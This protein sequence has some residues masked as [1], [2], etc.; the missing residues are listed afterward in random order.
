[1]R[2]FAIKLAY[3]TELIDCFRAS[4]FTK[5]LDPP[6]VQTDRNRHF[7]QNT[8]LSRKLE[9]LYTESFEKSF[10]LYLQVV[11]TNFCYIRSKMSNGFQ[12]SY[13]Y[14][15][16]KT[17]HISL[18]KIIMQFGVRSRQSCLNFFF[19]GGDTMYS[20]S[21]TRFGDWPYSVSSNRF[22]LQ[23]PNRF[24]LTCTNVANDLILTQLSWHSDITVYDKCASRNVY[25]IHHLRNRG[26]FERE[27][28]GTPLPTLKCFK[29][30]LWTQLRTIFW[31]ICTRLH[32]FAY[33]NP[34][35]FQ[36]IS[37]DTRRNVPGA[38]IHT[39]ISAWLASV[40]IVTV[41]RNNHWC[42]I[43]FYTQNDR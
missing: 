15:I 34:T 41:L 7:F 10:A 8:V 43:M 17:F 32:D 6:L 14:M 2:A 18:P 22:R 12:K 42:L 4:P 20:F 37:P 31:Q 29:N 30:A 1:M 26:H 36:A 25:V 38:W 35:F 40:P 19:L 33:T 3:T 21:V 9:I 27:R 11:W 16:F 28:V 39:P 23:S 5:C 24:M 13:A